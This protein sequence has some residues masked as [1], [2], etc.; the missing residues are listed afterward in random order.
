MPNWLIIS[1]RAARTKPRNFTNA[2]TYAG[3]LP[4]QEIGLARGEVLRTELVNA[5]PGPV[6]DSLARHRDAQ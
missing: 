4:G 2:W 1:S 5:L 3:T 6:D